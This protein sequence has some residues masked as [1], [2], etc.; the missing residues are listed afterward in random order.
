[1]QDLE[2]GNF[3]FNPSKDFRVMFEDLKKNLS[4]YV[5]IN[6]EYFK[7]KLQEEKIKVSK[8]IKYLKIFNKRLEK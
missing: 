3:N 4:D 5:E 2:P 1:L 8:H 6:N 7:I